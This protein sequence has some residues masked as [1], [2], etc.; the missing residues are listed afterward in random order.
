M[1]CLYQYNNLEL[2]ILTIQCMF[3]QSLHFKLWFTFLPQFLLWS[4][5]FHCW[6]KTAGQVVLF[7][8]I[9]LFIDLHVNTEFHD[10]TIYYCCYCLCI[11]G[12]SCY[13]F[14]NITKN[15]WEQQGKCI[16]FF[17]WM[18][19]PYNSTH[20][21]FLMKS[22]SYCIIIIHCFTKSIEHHI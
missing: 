3:I 20:S 18:Q 21:I 11:T 1:L 22:L 7:I 8:R 19:F 2:H 6:K 4:H 5:N 17:D 12:H 9:Q 15:H 10:Y 13:C 14:V 16:Y